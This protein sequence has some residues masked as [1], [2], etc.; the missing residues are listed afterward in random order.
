MCEYARIKL[1]DFTVMESEE[2]RHSYGV[3]RETRVIAPSIV[4]HSALSWANGSF[5]TARGKM[6]VIWAFQQ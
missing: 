2:K 4:N 5:S 6:V 3:R 1:Y